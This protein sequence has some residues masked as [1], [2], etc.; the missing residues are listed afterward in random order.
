MAICSHG[1]CTFVTRWHT[2]ILDIKVTGYR[3]GKLM[4]MMLCCYDKL[5]TVP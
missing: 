5:T 3:Q 4:E 2:K 1:L